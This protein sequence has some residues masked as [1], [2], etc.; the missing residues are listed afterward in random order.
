MSLRHELRKRA[1]RAAAPAVLAG[2]VLYLGYHTVQGD[3]GLAAWLEIDGRIAEQ[4]AELAVV[5]VERARMDRRVELMRA[6]GLDPDLLD[7]RARALLNMARPDERV[8]F[9]APAK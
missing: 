6:D 5:R 4:R 7:E 3:R 8:Y 9:F 1:K 2:V